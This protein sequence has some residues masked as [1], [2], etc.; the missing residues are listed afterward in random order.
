M[1]MTISIWIVLSLLAGAS[2]TVIFLALT[3]DL[4]NAVRALRYRQQALI[5]DGIQVRLDQAHLGIS[6]AEFI[7][8]SVVL[9]L[10]L[11]LALYVVVG[12]L[13]LILI[14]FAAGFLIT[15]TQLEVARDRK[16]VAY[17][18]TLASACDTLRNAYLT[19]GSLSTAIKSVV[20]YG[21]PEVRD[22][23]ALALTAARQGEFAA[24]LQTI[25]N[26]RRSIVFD[27]MANALLRAEESSGA[28]GE[29]L[30]QLAESTRQN[31]AAFEAAM[32]MQINARSNVNWGAFG[33]WAVYAAFRLMTVGF[34]TV[35]LG[36]ASDFFGTLPGN[37]VAALAGVLTIYLH[38]M[39]YQI[40]QRDLAVQRV[41]TSDPAAFREGRPAQAM[42]TFVVGEM[43]AAI[44]ARMR[45]RPLGAQGG[46][47]V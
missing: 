27:A 26:R 40:A 45:Q 12:A 23:F 9:G 20:E 3:V 7:K 38:R 2:L 5:S 44:A 46:G 8:R 34:S 4:G 19:S 31:V 30:E 32:I 18:Q 13:T 24:G 17:N 47:H 10:G 29:M 14:G 41:E 15:W 36:G 39:C 1:S 28:V 33:P 37:L 6:A 43:Q 25:A 35:S 42:P 21:A 11:A 16:L 22:D